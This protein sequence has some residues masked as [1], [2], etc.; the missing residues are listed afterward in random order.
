MPLVCA[1][2]ADE[3]VKQ[4][5]VKCHRRIRWHPGTPRP[6]QGGQH[7]RY[8]DLAGGITFVSASFPGFLLAIPVSAV[9]ADL[10]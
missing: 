5:C 10:L 3:I 1:Q 4:G 6:T 8:A 2:F 7:V 9:L